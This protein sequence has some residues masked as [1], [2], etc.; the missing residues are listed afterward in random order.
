MSRAC[1]QNEPDRSST[2]TLWTRVDDACLRFEAAWQEGQRPAIE[3]HLGDM[4]EPGR[5]L[6]LRELIGLELAYR[7]RRG[8]RPTLEEYQQRFAEHPELIRVVFREESLLLPDAL[9]GEATL[10]QTT[11][12]SR[13]GL[14][15]VP[16]YEVLSKLGAGGMGVVYKARQIALDRVVALKMILGAPHASTEEL[17]RFRTEAQAIARLQHPHIVQIY[18]VGECD[19][20]PFFSLEFCPGGSL[21]KKLEAT[22]LPPR[23]AAQLVETLAQAMQAAHDQGIL[24][25]DL[26]PANVLLQI[27]ESGRMKDEKTAEDSIDSSPHP[28]SFIPKITDFGLAKKLDAK[29]ITASGAILGT[30]NYMAPEQASSQVKA[31]GRAADIYGLG[32]IL[33]ECLTG[34]P[35]FKAASPAET[36]LL[37]LRE[38]P[39]A[40]KQLNARIP[41]D[42]ETICLK[43]LQKEPARRY[44][45]ALDL[46]E[47]LRRFRE[48]LPIQARPAGWWERMVKWARRRPAAAAAAAVVVAAT[49]L[50]VAGLTAYSLE[51]G[52]LNTALQAK[53]KDAQQQKVEAQNA[54]ALAKESEKEVRRQAYLSAFGLAYRLWEAGQVRRTQE[55][56]AGLIPPGAKPDLPDFEWRYLERQCCAELHTLPG[57][58]PDDRSTVLGDRDRRIAFSPAEPQLAWAYKHC[59]AVWDTKAQRLVRIFPAHGHLVAAVAF[60]PGGQWLASGGADRKVRLWKSDFSG[61]ALQQVLEGRH[62][63]GVSCICF[64][65]GGGLLASAGEDGVVKTWDVATMR[66]QCSLIPPGPKVAIKS[67]A[68]SPDGKRLA[69]A[70]ADG[71]IALWEMPAAAEQPVLLGREG[72]AVVMSIAFLG[73]GA[74]GGGLL[75]SGSADGIVRLWDAETG[76]LEDSF[77]AHRF[78]VACVC[79]RSDGKLASAGADGIVRVW[80]IAARQLAFA[81]RGHNAAVTALA[82]SPDGTRL[83]SFGRDKQVKIWDTMGEKDSRSFRGNHRRV[84]GVAFSSNKHLASVD[85]EGTVV[86]WDRATGQTCLRF[87]AERSPLQRSLAYSPDGRHLA[88]SMTDLTVKVWQVADPGKESFALKGHQRNIT[89]LTFSSDGLF[90]ASSSMDHT[91]KVW[92]AADGRELFTFKG[93]Q[94]PVLGVAVSTDGRRLA[95]AGADKTVRVWDMAKKQELLMLQ[96]HQ[97]AVTAVAFSPDGRCLASAG[98]DRTVRLWDAE[99]GRALWASQ[100]HEEDISAVAFSPEGRRLASAGKDRTVRLWDVAT[101]LELLVLSARG[102]PLNGVA[103][104]PDGCFLA[105]AGD[106]TDKGVTDPKI[107]DAAVLIWDGTPL[108]PEFRARRLAERLVW[109]LYAKAP[110]QAGVLQALRE[111]ASLAEAVRREAVRLAEAYGRDWLAPPGP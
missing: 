94:G 51:V 20:L 23:E 35:P 46:A 63:G 67:V 5:T 86:V 65:P 84:C 15:V 54:R 85:G 50:L 11:P 33:Y 75:V 8:E 81:L 39:A 102:Q 2:S 9:A 30:P 91:V 104:S 4:A 53:E 71:R 41:R 19:G 34:R 59:I 10:R 49:L 13:P 16:G 12:V 106:G 109:T 83:A 6:L 37:V 79:C 48:G 101:G 64:S 36:L 42:L 7:L 78:S 61:P 110:G 95:S 72:S 14:P 18:E 60:S 89:A 66:E 56:L 25:R 58:P 45:S 99:N 47:D 88:V 32:A 1:Q 107:K 57:Y 38:E 103:F 28:S 70:R 76:Q 74:G 100:G 87:A 73:R 26:K 40:P 96:G 68:F 31:I 111:D 52:A 55:I 93:H 98:S 90:L 108:D 44:A 62:N 29:A 17:E 69:A 82:F 24:H 3:V 43:C 77:F 22:P 80:D 27:D 105:A 92:N 97:D 21:D